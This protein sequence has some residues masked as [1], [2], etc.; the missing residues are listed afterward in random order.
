M[1]LVC[2]TFVRRQ[3]VWPVGPLWYY[4][5]A[6]RG[7]VRHMRTSAFPGADVY[8]CEPTRGVTER[9]GSVSARI[10]VLAKPGDYLRI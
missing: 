6:G 9:W 8:R 10:L 3:G 4:W 1:L 5:T 7:R 2:D